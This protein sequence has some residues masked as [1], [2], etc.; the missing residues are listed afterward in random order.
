MYGDIADQ[1]N[2]EIMTL[3]IT[4]D[5]DHKLRGRDVPFYY[6]FLNGEGAETLRNYCKLKHK[7]STP[8]TPLFSTKGKKHVTQRWVWQVVKMC[9]ERA[10]FKPRTI[11]THTIRKTFRKIV[12]QADIDDDDKEQLMGHV[13][14]GSREAYFDKKDV[15]LIREAYLKS[16]FVR[17]APESEVTKLRR[18]LEDSETKRML[19]DARLETLEKQV[20][21]LIAQVKEMTEK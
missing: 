19:Q 6:T 8:D 2:E 13:I 14:P 15:E 1:L 5:L 12:R 17:E 4:G 9:T 10:G 11:S 7:T 3:K 16:N 20:I 18:Q 21:N